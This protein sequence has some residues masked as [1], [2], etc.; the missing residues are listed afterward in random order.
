MS[1]DTSWV[2]AMPEVYDRELGPALFLP[3]AEQLAGLAAGLAPRRVL[4]LAAGTGILTRE[5]LRALP[6]A[7][8]TAT[9]LNAAMVV[10]AAER[11][12]G[13]T[14]RQADAQQ[15][16]LPDGCVDLVACQFGA[17]FFPDRPAAYAE[18]ARVLVPGGTFLLSVWDVVEGS[19]LSAVMVECL[20]A[21]WPEDPPG[22]LVRVPHGYADPDLVRTDLTAGGLQV[23]ALDRVVLRGQASSPRGLAEGF[24]LGSPLRFALQE[25]G[26]LDALTRRLGDEMTARL[27]DGPVEGELAAWVGSAVRPG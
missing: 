11:V 3:Y 16:D 18:T 14:W 5:L 9:D 17:M 22:F 21:V 15:L 26:D 25:R 24:C 27:G 13:A 7:E 1:S 12:P 8:V 20:A 10:W 4:E 23:T 6:D 2:D 19:Q